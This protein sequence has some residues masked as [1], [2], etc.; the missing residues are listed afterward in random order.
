ME[1][2]QLGKLEAAQLCKLELA[3]PLQVALQ[4]PLQLLDGLSGRVDD[5]FGHL[6]LKVYIFRL[7]FFQR[8]GKTERPEKIKCNV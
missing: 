5:A 8:G 6:V 2:S 7:E 1:F 4:L 3:E